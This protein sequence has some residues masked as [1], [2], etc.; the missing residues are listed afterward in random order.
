MADVCV[1]EFHHDLQIKGT[2]GFGYKKRDNNEN[3]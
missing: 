1:T 2:C 3:H